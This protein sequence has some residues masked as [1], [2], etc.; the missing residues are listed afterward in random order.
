MLNRPNN[1]THVIYKSGRPSTLSFYRRLKEDKRPHIVG[2]S[3]VTRSKEKGERLDEA[4]FVID[5]AE[6]DVFQK[7]SP[8]LLRACE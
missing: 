3:W 5:I 6:E 2:I 1:V 7:V 8:S 4:P